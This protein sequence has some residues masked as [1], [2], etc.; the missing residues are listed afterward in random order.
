MKRERRLGWLGG[1]LTDAMEPFGS[2]PDWFTG[3]PFRLLE[4]E[5]RAT[6]SSREDPVAG[7]AHHWARDPL[8]NSDSCNGPVT[9]RCSPAGP[10]D[11]A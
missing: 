3:I 8:P 2:A 7:V 4:F 5:I 6:F 11:L 1:L 9:W 10:L